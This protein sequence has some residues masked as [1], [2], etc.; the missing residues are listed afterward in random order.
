MYN[1]YLLHIFNLSTQTYKK[2]GE[3]VY[4]DPAGGLSILSTDSFT[5]RVFMTNSTFVSC[6]FIRKDSHKLC[7]QV[8]IFLKKSMLITRIPTIRLLKRNQNRVKSFF[9]IVTEVLRDLLSS[10]YLTFFPARGE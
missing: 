9:F 3:L 1:K 8:K 2:D 10:T 5:T 7:V 6:E 4:R